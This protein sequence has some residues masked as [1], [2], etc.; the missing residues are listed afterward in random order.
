MVAR[1]ARG[2]KSRRVR[3]TLLLALVTAM[4]ITAAASAAAS[5]G[6]RAKDADIVAKAEKVLAAG[7]K[8]LLY[9]PGSETACTLDNIFTD[10]KWH[11]PKSAPT[12][13]KGKKIVIIPVVNGGEPLL[14]TQGI[15][16]AAQA[17]GWS[18]KVIAG[19]GTPSSYQKAFQ[20][21]LATKPDAIVLVSIPENQVG[22][23]IPESRK[24]GIKLVEAEGYPPPSGDKY[25]AYVTDVSGITA[26]IEA[27]HAIAES[28]GTAKALLFWDPSAVSLRAG[29]NGATAEF[30]KCSGCKVLGSYL[31][32]SSL[33]VNP[34][35]EAAAVSSLLHKYGS[36]LQYLLTSYGFGLQSVA[37]TVA[38]CHCPTKVLTKN[39]EQAS[40]ALIQQGLV[41]V[42]SGTDSTW[43]GWAS[44]DQLV[45]LF[46]GEKPLGPFSEGVPVHIFTKANLPPKNLW[47][48]PIDYKKKYKQ[49]WGVH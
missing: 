34:T 26:K 48:A 35:K 3:R 30:A 25:D 12:P 5:S 16:N 24:R 20:S 15:Q 29:L 46:A 36:D 2:R 1:I 33:G 10:S 4:G 6:S 17:L 13:A 32:S 41:G 22:N 28:K 39:G 37:T 38:S 47:V 45:R 21:A 14:A 19:E 42:D 23:Y 9:C 18:T 27:W 43:I 31:I 11:G 7:Q 44:V 49:I 8:G 40:L